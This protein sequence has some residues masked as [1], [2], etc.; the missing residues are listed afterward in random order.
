MILAAVVGLQK[1]AAAQSE[2][3]RIVL[4]LCVG[5]FLF[6]Y[7]AHLFENSSLARAVLPFEAW[8]GLNHDNPRRR[9][10]V[11]RELAKIP[12]ELLV[13]VHYQYPQHPF[14]DEWVY[15]AADI[16]RARIVWAR[17]LGPEQ[18]AELER[19][20][21]NRK[22]LMLKP[23]ENPPEIETPAPNGR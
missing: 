23:D 7:M 2:A 17:D 8:D 15:N 14:Q 16:D 6:W 21:P 10:Y 13:F 22:A 3:A 11:E 12:G 9:I 20:Y 18:D 19:Y 1:L 5:H 4:F